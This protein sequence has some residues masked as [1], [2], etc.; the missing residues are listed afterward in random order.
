MPATTTIP[1]ESAYYKLLVR[2]YTDGFGTPTD[3]A[4]AKR[5]LAALDRLISFAANDGR[6]GNPRPASRYRQCA[7]KVSDLAHAIAYAGG[8]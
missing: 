1:P 7:A 5:W 8:L 3:K 4:R 6:Y 2:T